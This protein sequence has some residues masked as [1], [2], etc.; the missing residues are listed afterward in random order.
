MASRRFGPSKLPGRGLFW[1]LAALL[2]LVLAGLGF[3]HSGG[4]GPT[5]L[6]DVL[7]GAKTANAAP[8]N[9]GPNGPAAGPNH[10][11]PKQHPGPLSG[12][13]N[14]HNFTCHP[15]VHAHPNNHLSAGDTVNVTI[16][17]NCPN[18]SFSVTFQGGG[19]STTIPTDN[20]GKGSGTV[21][22]GGANG[23]HNI[24]A[25]DSQGNFGSTT[26]TVDHGGGPK[27]TCNPNIHVHPAT[28]APGG[29]LNIQID[30]NCPSGDTFKVTVDDTGTPTF[31]TI[32]KNHKGSGSATAP[33]QRGDYTVSAVDGSGNGAQTTIHV[34]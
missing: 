2:A 7:S 21:M 11:P 15:N 8:N 23:K 12:G 20:S 6:S 27:M 17:G 26:V 34:H 19:S 5:S 13:N 10:K 9:A 3:E 30:G 1:L 32:G 28:V 29:M 31:I 33:T 24:T 4:G 16:D 14:G 25:Q 22:A 18:D